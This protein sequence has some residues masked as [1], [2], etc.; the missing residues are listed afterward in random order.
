MA[1]KEVAPA[2]EQQAGTEGPASVSWMIAAVTEAVANPTATLDRA[3]VIARINPDRNSLAWEWAVMMKSR[4]HAALYDYCH[5][6]V[7]ADS[8]R[9]NEPQAPSPVYLPSFV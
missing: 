2:F 8:S 1:G 9:W 4:N 3:A 7:P 5:W 6:Q